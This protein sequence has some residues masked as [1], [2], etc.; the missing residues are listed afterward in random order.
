[1]SEFNAAAFVAELEWMGVKLTAVPLADGTMRINRWRMLHASENIQ[2]IQQ[3]WINELGENQA[4]I[5]LLASFL[6][7][8]TATPRATADRGA[9]TALALKKLG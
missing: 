6:G 9:V 4:R 2:R 1:M 8:R 3:L 7:A 5:A